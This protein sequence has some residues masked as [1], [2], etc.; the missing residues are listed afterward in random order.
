MIALST[1]KRLVARPRADI[2]HILGERLGWRARI[3]FEWARDLQQVCRGQLPKEQKVAVLRS[4]TALYLRRLCQN[5]HKPITFS[6]LNFRVSAFSLDALSFLYKEIF[7]GLEYYFES[8]N[9]RP[10]IID[11]GSNIGMSILFFKTVYPDASI[12]GFEP[13][14]DSFGLLKRN[15]EANQLTNVTVYPLALGYTEGTVKFFLEEE[16]G[17]FV[18]STDA[19]RVSKREET[20]EMMRLSRFVDREVDFL[21]LDVEG[22]E[23]AV[24]DDLVQTGCIRR[25]SQMVVEYHHHLDGCD[26]RFSDFLLQLERN[27]FGYLIRSDLGPSRTQGR[28]QDILVYAYR[29]DS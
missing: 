23:G 4:M 10:F 18:A 9:K 14:P 1:E 8:K 13:A 11:C 20:V 28:F 29:K 5:V 7:L 16:P 6:L 19:R 24:L 2:R 25:I 12:L 22:A 15:V 17:G 26:D 3:P 27:G 21:K